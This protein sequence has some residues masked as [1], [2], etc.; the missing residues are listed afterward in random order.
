MECTP[1]KMPAVGAALPEAA[2]AAG[3]CGEPLWPILRVGFICTKSEF[4]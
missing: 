1:S 3:F 4:E 2:A